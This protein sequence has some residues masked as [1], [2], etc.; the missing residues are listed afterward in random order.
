MWFFPNMMTQ[1]ALIL[2]GL[3]GLTG[4]S[5]QKHA[6]SPDWTRLGQIFPNQTMIKAYRFHVVQPF[7]HIF[8]SSENVNSP[9]SVIT[10]V[11]QITQFIDQSVI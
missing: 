4:I 8:S 1:Y 3:V 10:T 11:K 2:P 6:G 5:M 9:G 7:K